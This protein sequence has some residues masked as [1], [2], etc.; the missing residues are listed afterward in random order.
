[1]LARRNIGLFRY[2]TLLQTPNFALAA[3]VLLLSWF[4]TYDYYS[5]NPRSILQSTF[6]FLPPTIINELTTNATKP[7]SSR[8]FLSPALLPFI[9]LHTALTLLL[10]LASHVQI[11]LRVSVANPVIF[12]Y[13]ADLMTS[14]DNDAA[15]LKRKRWGERWIKY[16]CVWG[17]IAGLLWSGY[18]P[19]A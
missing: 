2:W 10:L 19:P 18:Y 6:P 15:G 5:H 4:A 14:T 17:S 7:P 9:H 3:P 8:L 1:M 11:I 12:W 13:V 16:C